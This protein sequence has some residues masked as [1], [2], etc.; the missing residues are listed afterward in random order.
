MKILQRLINIEKMVGIYSNFE[1]ALNEL[2]LTRDERDNLFDEFRELYELAK[3][4][5]ETLKPNQ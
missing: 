4:I 5:N 1:N 2:R 3:E